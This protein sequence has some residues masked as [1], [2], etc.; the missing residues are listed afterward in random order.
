MA[1]FFRNCGSEE[2]VNNTGLVNFRDMA[3]NFSSEHPAAAIFQA[4][5]T[6]SSGEQRIVKGG[7]LTNLFLPLDPYTRLF[8]E[9]INLVACLILLSSLFLPHFSF[10]LARCCHFLGFCNCPACNPQCIGW[11]N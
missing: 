2:H 7:F 9:F 3:T 10:S 1:R 6:F 8:P 11:C 4:Y 5:Y